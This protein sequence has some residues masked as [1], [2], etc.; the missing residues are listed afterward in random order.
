M[1]LFR[2]VLVF[3]GV[4]KVSPTLRAVETNT[5]KADKAAKDA[6][7]SFKNLAGAFTALVV[8]TKVKQALVGLLAPTI[9]FE[10]AMKRLKA[11]SGASEV[12][13]KRFGETAR[14]AAEKTIFGPIEAVDALA[15]L[16]RST[17]DAD[18]A[19]RLLGQT[20]AVAQASFGRLTPEK[21]A[22][23]LGQMVRAFGLVGA[24]SDKA[25]AA[26]DKMFAASRK[27]GVAIPEMTKVMG[28]LAEAAIRG[29]QSFEDMTTSFVLARRVMSSSRRTA[30]QLIRVMSELGG[31]KA[32]GAFD[33][34]RIQT[35]DPFT[36]KIISM[37]ELFT[38]LLIS[39]RE[40]AGNVKRVIAKAFDQAAV[41]P[42]IAILDQMEKGTRDLNGEW[43]TGIKVLDVYG[44][45]M[46]KSG[47]AAAKEAA[48]AM[49]TAFGALQRLTEG[50]GNF[51]IV[52]GK[53]LTP[54][55]TVLADGVAG[56]TNLLRSV[57]EDM[58]KWA[59]IL[60][61]F[62]TGFLL[63]RTGI[64]VV[65]ATLF[66]AKALFKAT[67]SI[68]T[69]GVVKNTAAVVENT[70]A[71]KAQAAV[72]KTQLPLA[73]AKTIVAT[74]GATTATRALTAAT[75]GLKWGVKALL[76]STGI[77]LLIAFLPEIIALSKWLA[78]V[79]ATTAGA[80][81]DWMNANVPLLKQM[82][83]FESV[84]KKS[85]SAALKLLKTLQDASLTLRGLSFVTGAGKVA[86]DAIEA[87]IKA[88]KLILELQRKQE[89]RRGRK[90][91]ERAKKVQAILTIGT[92]QFDNAT[93]KLVKLLGPKPK[94][95]KESAV[96]AM[97][98]LLLQIQKKGKAGGEFVRAGVGIKLNASDASRATAGLAGMDQFRSIISR[99]LKG[100]KKV[101]GEEIKG[102]EAGLT[103]AVIALQAAAPQDVEAR[104]RFMENVVRPFFT[105]IG[106]DA[107]KVAGITTLFGGGRSI[108]TGKKL[109]GAEN[110]GRL[111]AG[112]G[113]P[114]EGEGG[115]IGVAKSLLGLTPTAKGPKGGAGSKVDQEEAKNRELKRTE[116]AEK[117]SMNSD[118]QVALMSELVRIASDPNKSDPRENDPHYPSPVDWYAGR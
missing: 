96:Q 24:N 42:V 40:D 105:S 106:K 70:I 11:I 27:A 2:T 107:R 59:E 89:E 90:E 98:N 32:V 117:T 35:L 91:I 66:G 85:P 3:L 104:K 92:Q 19:M 94:L 112:T 81:L 108:A 116:A 18:D 55:I 99:V 101:T 22:D 61:R 52:I 36:S 14:D 56:L 5:K 15:A 84:L 6:A 38:K 58:P 69:G 62:A 80:T 71:V 95:I 64:F 86:K 25:S 13:M 28:T 115:L 93:D 68:L 87:H 9:K 53:P 49:E 60:V 20:M 113:V 37:K 48:G 26:V 54:V 82:K 44:K 114:A 77:G 79:W 111:G 73:F 109:E 46:Q 110:I 65:R 1:N 118:K 83:E 88:N 16:Q 30:L 47:G 8:A 39:Y 100:D 102:A 78:K 34:I 75:K 7:G 29:N 43:V 67:M 45:V 103:A 41:R 31:D 74:K 10:F 17:G 76:S 4:D 50:F 23:Q 97:E 57:F 21:A 12:V 72:H 51:L 33:E 63:L